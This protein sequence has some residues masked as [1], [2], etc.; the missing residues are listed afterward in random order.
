MMLV[1]FHV[2]SFFL[3]IVV[4]MVFIYVFWTISQ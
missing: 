2:F 3:G 4:G 1:E